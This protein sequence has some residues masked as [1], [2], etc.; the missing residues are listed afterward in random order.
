TVE[1]NLHV[2]ES[3]N[4]TKIPVIVTLTYKDAYNKEHVKQYDLSL[5]V[6]SLD[7]LIRIGEV[8][9]AGGTNIYVIIVVVLVVAY[10]GYRYF[11]RRKAA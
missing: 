1:Y 7:E 9:P 10:L 2:D 6:Y 3:L 4:D 5:K 11:R 8:K